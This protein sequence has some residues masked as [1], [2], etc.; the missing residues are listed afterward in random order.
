MLAAIQMF[1]FVS[2]VVILLPSVFY[3]RLVNLFMCRVPLDSIDL[4][5]RQGEFDL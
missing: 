4:G 5:L 1:G 2:L 3:F